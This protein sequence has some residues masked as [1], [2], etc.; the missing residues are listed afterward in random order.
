MTQIASL[1]FFACAALDR[2]MFGLPPQIDVSLGRRKSY[3][4]S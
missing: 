2:E 3:N 4:P 1:T